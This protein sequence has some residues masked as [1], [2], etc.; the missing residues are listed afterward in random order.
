MPGPHLLEVMFLED[1]QRLVRG[2]VGWEGR[3]GG[4]TSVAGDG[5]LCGCEEFSG[6]GYAVGCDGFIERQRWKG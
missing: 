3:E 1:S 5:T 4:T 2:G 6:H